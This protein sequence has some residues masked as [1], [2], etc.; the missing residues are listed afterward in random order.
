[1][2]AGGEAAYAWAKACGILGKAFLGPRLSRL[3]PVGRLAE[4]DRLLF[5]DSPLQLP[6]RELSA[7]LER[8]ISERAA[9]RTAA[10]VAAFSDPP[11]ALSRLIAAFE[12]ADLSRCLAAVAAGER[13]RPAVVDL[14]RFGTVDFDAYPDVAKMTAGTEFT[15]LPDALASGRSAVEIGTELDG[16]YYRS[17]WASAASLGSADRRVFED[18]VAEEIALKNIVWAL[19]LR[20]YYGLGADELRAFLV[21]VER[22]GRSLAED[23]LK[24]A[25]FALDRRE[26]WLRWRPRYLLGGGLPGEGWRVDPR[27]VQGAAARRLYALARASFRR[28]PLSVGAFVC[29]AKLLQ[30]EEDLLTSVAEGLVLGIAPREVVSSLEASA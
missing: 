28:H 17:L 15:W 5:P 16:R 25:G 1:M 13:E 14:G 26:D 30:R 21:D 8:R 2:R 19:R 10:V 3:Y 22:D 24:A 6:E 11:A 23:A 12:Y 18:F 29:W 20:V 27:R 7:R 9:A 4:L